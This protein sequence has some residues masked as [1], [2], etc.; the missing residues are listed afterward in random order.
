MSGDE[1]LCYVPF[2]SGIASSSMYSSA[3]GSHCVVAMVI[4]V[5]L[6]SRERAQRMAK[7]VCVAYEG[8]WTYYLLSL[9]LSPRALAEVS[10]CAGGLFNSGV[11]GAVRYRKYVCAFHCTVLPFPADGRATPEVPPVLEQL[12]THV[13]DLIVY[14][15]HDAPLPQ[16]IHSY[17][18]VM[19]GDISGS[20]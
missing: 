9:Y 10:N 16:T 19:F 12:V 13:P 5:M 20:P 4:V 8:R 11:G 3:I 1:R 17:G 6:F 15:S 14:R 7:H 18:V 2:I